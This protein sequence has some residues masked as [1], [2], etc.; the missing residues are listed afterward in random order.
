MY[1]IDFYE[2]GTAHLPYGISSRN[3]ASKAEVTKMH[4]FSMNKS[5]F[6]SIF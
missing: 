4:A 1:Q 5:S 3:C 2:K 6:I